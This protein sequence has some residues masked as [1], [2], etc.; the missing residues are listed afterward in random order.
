[1]LPINRCQTTKRDT[2]RGASQPAK[3]AQ[4]AATDAVDD[5]RGHKRNVKRYEEPSSSSS[6]SSSC[7]PVLLRQPSFQH[8]APTS[9]PPVSSASHTPP[10]FPPPSTSSRGSGTV[11]E[12]RPSQARKG[13]VSREGTTRSPVGQGCDC[14][15]RLGLRQHARPL[16]RWRSLLCPKA[17]VRNLLLHLLG[18]GASLRSPWGGILAARCDASQLPEKGESVCAW[19]RGRGGGGRRGR[20]R[21]CWSFLSFQALFGRFLKYVLVF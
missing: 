4:R 12:S 2:S 19:G 9:R 13:K 3:P 6:S 8:S 14:P 16:P 11:V 7:P 20:G 21:V 1:M 15:L 10:P 18:S 17:D 5:E